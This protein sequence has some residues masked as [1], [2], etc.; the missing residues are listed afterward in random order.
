MASIYPTLDE[1]YTAP[2]LLVPAFYLIFAFTP[3]VKTRAAKVSLLI[4]LITLAVSSP[5]FHDQNLNNDYG[6]GLPSLTIPILFLDLFLLSPSG[7]VRFIGS[8][9]D[10]IDKDAG[11]SEH[12][13]D[14]LW[15]RL[16]WG[17]RLVASSRGI[18]WTWQ[19]K[20]VPP[21]PDRHL[22]RLNFVLK[23]S[24]LSGLSWIYK[25]GT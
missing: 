13:C 10:V 3:F 5:Y 19:V 15:K 14:T 20:G 6:R 4:L 23:Y 8:V 18:G 17:L 22:I 11:L 25:T 16:K 7:T 12:D 9:E 1:R 2:R 24:V 21:H